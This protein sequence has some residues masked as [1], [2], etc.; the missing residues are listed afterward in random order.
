M[1]PE[2]GHAAGTL[3]MWALNQKA[4][5][6][7]ILRGHN[8]NPDRAYGGIEAA[9]VVSCS[10]SLKSRSDIYKINL[11]ARLGEKMVSGYVC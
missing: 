4:G 11:L 3:P 7:T 5:Y 8:M 1:S 9:S 6:R 2:I 10:Q